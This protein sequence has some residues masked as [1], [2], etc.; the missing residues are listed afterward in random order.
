MI[1]KLD[2]VNMRFGDFTALSELNCEIEKKEIFGIAGPNGAGKTTLFNVITGTLP[3][4]GNI[5]F[6]GH[7]INGLKPHKICNLG[8]ARTFQTPQLFSTLTVFQNIKVGVHFG[9]QI[10]EKQ[11]NVIEEMINFVGLK[12]KEYELAENLTLIEKKLTM[13]ATALGTKPSILLLDEPISGLGE[14]D[15]D[16]FLRL[17]QRI[18]QELGITIIVIE[19]LMK[20]IIRLCDRLMILNNGQKVMIGPPLEV[21]KTKEVIDIYLGSGGEN[22]A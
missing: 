21:T 14:S 15:A 6:N 16:L 1:L 10:K 12:G 22:H 20:F 4:T 19:H 5:F 7:N 17:I 8:I 9:G 3:G 11:I 18:N 2:N 13:L